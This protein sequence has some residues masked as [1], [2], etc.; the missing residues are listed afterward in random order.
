MRVTGWS[1]PKPA[2]LTTT[3]FTRMASKEIPL[4]RGFVTIVDEEDYDFLIRWKWR[5][6]EQCGIFYAYTNATVGLKETAIIGKGRIYPHRQIITTLKMHRVII[7]AP[8]GLLVDH[9]NNNGLDN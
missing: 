1:L 5:V 2:T 3:E 9:K 4:T 7:N 8:K 6:I